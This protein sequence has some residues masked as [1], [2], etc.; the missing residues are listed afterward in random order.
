LVDVQQIPNQPLRFPDETMDKYKQNGR[1][2]DEMIS[3]AWDKY[4]R[5]KDPLWLPRLPMTKA[6]VRAMD[7]VQAEWPEVKGFFVFGGSKRGW[8]TWTTAAVD[9]RV[10]GITPA[11]IDVLNITKSLDNHHASYGFWAPAIG[12]YVEMDILSR[13]HTP[14][15]EEL[16]KVVDPFFYM[17]RLAMPKYIVNSAGDQ[18]F[19]PDSW[20]FYFDDLQ[21][22][23]YLCYMP[24]TDHD[25]NNEAYVNLAAFY[26]AVRVNAPLPKFAW[27]KSADGSLEVKCESK[28]TKVLL[29]Q[30]TNRE[31]RDFRLEK[32]GPAYTSSP[33]PEGAPGVYRAAAETPAKGWTAYFLE[34]EFPNGGFMFPLRF[35]T[36]VSI[37]PDT[38]PAAER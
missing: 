18:F 25:L 11:V 23:K 33:V 6:V 3:Y 27:T 9:K 12:D 36:G 1:S 32:I 5:T 31:A 10:I 2:E 19:P 34:M 7:L 38:Y 14:E 8:T 20:K 29:W 17:D 13:I 21:G 4:L 30:A 35:T 24:N 15:F 26:H 28:P 22:E 16:R 37:V